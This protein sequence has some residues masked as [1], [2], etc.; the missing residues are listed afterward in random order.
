[1]PDSKEI[2]VGD[3][4]TLF[5]I[6]LEDDS[7]DP[8]SAV[9]LTG[10]TTLEIIFFKPDKTKLTKI[11][12]LV[13]PATDGKISYTTISGDLNVAGKW[14]IQAHIVLLTGEWRSSFGEFVVKPNLC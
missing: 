13:G 2:H 8:H 4:G 1:M 14:L 11:A 12:L 3:I 9:D 7:T 5:E 6:T 10:N